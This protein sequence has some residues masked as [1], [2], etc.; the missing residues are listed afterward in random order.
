[1]RTSAPADALSAFLTRQHTG[2]CLGPKDTKPRVHVD[3]IFV[4]KSTK[5]CLNHIV[6]IHNLRRELL[7]ASSGM[8]RQVLAQPGFGSGLR[9]CPSHS[10]SAPCAPF[11]CRFLSVPFRPLLVL[12][13]PVRRHIVRRG[14]MPGRPPARRINRR[15]VTS[16]PL[17]LPWMSK[18]E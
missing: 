2:T 16:L 15:Q 4:R 3:C 11:P 10:A 18:P 5:R 12:I 6:T 1:M 8:F 9:A 14:L 13:M 7:A 17:H